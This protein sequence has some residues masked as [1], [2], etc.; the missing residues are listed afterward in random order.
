MARPGCNGSSRRPG[1]AVDAVALVRKNCLSLLGPYYNQARPLTQPSKNGIGGRDGRDARGERDGR[2]DR[3][4]G[5]VR[6][7]GGRC[8]D[9]SRYD[10]NEAQKS[11]HREFSVTPTERSGQDRHPLVCRSHPPPCS[12]S[13]LDPS[14][15]HDASPGRHK[16]ARLC[17]CFFFKLLAWAAPV[18]LRPVTRRGCIMEVRV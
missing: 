4:G 18:L 3:L 6:D 12:A 2:A 15:S 1:F 7:L 8:R 13:R 10:A 5:N 16:R 9:P 11:M 17:F 14:Q